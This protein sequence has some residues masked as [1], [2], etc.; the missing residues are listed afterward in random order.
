M[1]ELKASKVR[2][3]LLA[4]NVAGNFILNLMHTYVFEI[5][6]ALKVLFNT[7]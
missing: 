2:L 3:I 4:T 5:S 7:F 1:P 6:K